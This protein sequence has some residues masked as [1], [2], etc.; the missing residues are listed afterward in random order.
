[1]AKIVEEILKLPIGIA[2]KRLN[3][4]EVQHGSEFLNKIIT[5]IISCLHGGH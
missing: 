4:L 3:K 1:M 2:E 5:A